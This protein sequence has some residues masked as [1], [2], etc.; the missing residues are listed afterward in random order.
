MVDVVR[1][2]N[3]IRNGLDA[4]ERRL[5]SDDLR[6]LDRMLGVGLGKL[7]WGQKKG[8]E[9]FLGDCARACRGLELVVR[10]VQRGRRV[11]AGRVAKCA[12]VDL[13]GVDTSQVAGCR[14][15]REG[16]AAGRRGGGGAFVCWWRPPL[17]PLWLCREEE[18]R[19][20]PR[21]WASFLFSLLS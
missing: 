10:Q 3:S 8:V 13:L 4:R 12:A 9:K 14:A 7:N 2:Y 19:R 1:V 16:R 20:P 5:L 18:R 11:V 21:T 17:A 15:G 6:K